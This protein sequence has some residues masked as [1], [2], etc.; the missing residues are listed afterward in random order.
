MSKFTDELQDVNVVNAHNFYVTMGV[1]FISFMPGSTGRFYQSA[2]W[3]VFC[4]GH[5]TDPDAHFMDHKTK[6]FSVS[7]YFEKGS[8]KEIRANKLAEAKAW[9][10][11]RY[12]VK[13]WAKDPFGSWGEETYVKARTK[14]LKAKI[15]AAPFR[16][17]DTVRVCDEGELRTVACI[18]VN[19]V[20]LEGDP[21]GLRA[22]FYKDS[23]LT[24]VDIGK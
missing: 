10:E 8:L 16:T 24:K 20:M 11:K 6:T 12:G 15:K 13:S 21:H 23:E 17:G 3:C 18:T 1:V 5:E 4:Q 7:R 9:A 22:V 14:A 19:G 2:K